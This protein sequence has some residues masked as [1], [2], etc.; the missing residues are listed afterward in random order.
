MIVWECIH[1]DYPQGTFANRK[2]FAEACEAAGVAYPD[3][4]SVLPLGVRVSPQGEIVLEPRAVMPIPRIAEDRMRELVNGVL[5]GS[6]LTTQ[7]MRAAQVPLS[8]LPVALGVLAPPEEL[9]RVLMGSDA[10]PE[11]PDPPDPPDEPVPDLQVGAPARPERL[12]LR[13]V[14]PNT[15]SAHEWGEIGDGEWDAHVT[16]VEEANR[17]A[18]AE[19]QRAL[20]CWE[21]ELEGYAASMEADK[22]DFDRAMAVYKEERSAW[23]AATAEHE[24][25]KAGWV[26]VHDRVFGRWSEDIGVLVGD[27]KDAFPR[28]VNG[29]PMFHAFS[30]IH[31]E[32]WMR[33]R[34]AIDREEERR[35]N[36]QV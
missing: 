33:V 1:P 19:H 13:T 23:E 28:G 2:A 35:G 5:N 15:Q 30:T 16:E 31:R 32:D 11:E 21:R 8:F 4:G 20:R 9:R 18:A 12:P 3:K 10:P 14:D 22:A 36:V 17:D 6:L 25:V 7:Q 26:E 29:Y 27:I 34:E 24:E